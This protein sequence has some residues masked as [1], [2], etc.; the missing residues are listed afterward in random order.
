MLARVPWTPTP[1]LKRRVKRINRDKRRHLVELATAV[2]RSGE[3]SLFAFEA[4]C[5]HG[6]RSRFCLAGW[7][8]NDADALAEDIVSEALRLLGAKRPTWEEGQ[9]EYVQNGGGALIER[10]RC[11]RCHTPLPEGHYKFCSRLCGQSHRE[12][13]GRR[14]TMSE[15]K[16][17]D[18]IVNPRRYSQW[19]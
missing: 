6:L 19:F 12:I 14:Q 9:P 18:T 10:T 5:R 7:K 2:L 11:V 8:W 17:I 15:D 1:K 3:A 4:T 16:V 13:L